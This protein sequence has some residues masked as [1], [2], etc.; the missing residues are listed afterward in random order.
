[1]WFK[2]LMWTGL[3]IGFIGFVALATSVWIAMQSLPSFEEL[4]QSPNGQT[5]RVHAADGSILMTL[6][7]T[8]GRWLKKEEI[9]QIMT[10]AMVAVEDRRF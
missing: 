6:G 3:T 7:P 8:Y 2:R 4:K 5:I 10:N 9:P 1:M